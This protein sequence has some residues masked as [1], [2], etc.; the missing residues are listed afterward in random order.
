VAEIR[1]QTARGFTVY[2]LAPKSRGSGWHIIY[3]HG[4][5][6]V[7]ELVPAHWAIIRELLRA[8]GATVIVPIYP[9]APEH[10]YTEAFDFLEEVY[11]DVL[12]T[13][14]AARIVLCGDSAGGNLALT[15]A[16]NYRDKGI[17]LPA[18]LILFSPGLDLTVSNP[19]IPSI[20]PYDVMLRRAEMLE[21]CRWWASGDDP[22]L[23]LLSPLFADLRGLPPVQIFQGTYDILLPD[24]RKLR[25]RLEEAGGHAE[26]YETPEG[27]HVFMGATFTREAKRV[28]EQVASGLGVV[29]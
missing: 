25:D 12:R 13:T 6:F 14:S 27:F 10:R 7:H 1:Q 5:S 23:P 8:T 29:A 9:L 15:Q 2:T 22:R 28:F 17:P 26:L 3:T 18:R 16:L 11:R 19:E 21:Y 24:A 4:G 20:E